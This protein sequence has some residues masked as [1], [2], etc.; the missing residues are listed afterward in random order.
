MDVWIFGTYSLFFFKLTV[1]D[2]DR[3]SLVVYDSNVEVVFGLMK[4]TKENRKKATA[5]VSSI[6]DGSSTNLCG[7]LLKG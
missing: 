3:I 1:K 6:K 5:F 4:M 2:T 7:G